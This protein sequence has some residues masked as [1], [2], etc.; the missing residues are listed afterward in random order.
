LIDGLIAGDRFGLDFSGQDGTDGGVECG[1]NGGL[2]D[3]DIVC[4]EDE[5]KFRRES[6]EF[7]DGG[8]VGGRSVSGRYSQILRDRK[9]LR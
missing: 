9:C 2:R 1:R 8:E 5:L 7:F 3:R 4:A 6:D